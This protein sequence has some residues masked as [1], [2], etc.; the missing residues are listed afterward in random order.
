MTTREAIL[1]GLRRTGALMTMFTR[2]LSRQ[3]LHHRVVP[4]AN[5]AAWILGHLALGDRN[6]LT[7]LG[8]ETLPALPYEDFDKRFARDEV[9]PRAEHFGD[10]ELLPQVFKE[11]RDALVAAVEAL[12]ES[13]FN[14]PLP[15]PLPIAATVGELL[16]FMPIH[17]AT[18][19]GQISTIRRSLGRPPLA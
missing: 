18:H 13:R 4:Q 11:H 5:C 6:M 8:V 19:I 2:D 3:D 17:A 12:E 16:L 15:K 14:E 9:A 7:S 1:Y 10:A